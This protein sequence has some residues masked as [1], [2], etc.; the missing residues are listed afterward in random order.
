MARFSQ[1][2]NSNKY[3]RTRGENFMQRILIID[4][5]PSVRR[6]LSMMLEGEGYDV[7]VAM[8]GE[9]GLQLFRR[10]GNFDL[11]ITDI[12]MPNIDGNKVGAYIRNSDKPDTPLIAITAYPEEV[13]KNIFDFSLTKPFKLKDVNRIVKSFESN[14]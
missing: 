10:P 12:R 13:Q 5:E 3:L 11:V 6:L 1:N 7:E 14:R 8:D 4:D 2:Q 9:Q